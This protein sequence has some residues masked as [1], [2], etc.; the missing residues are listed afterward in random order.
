MTDRVDPRP[1]PLHNTSEPN[2]NRTDPRVES[3]VDPGHRGSDPNFENIIWRRTLGAGRL[4]KISVVRAS[5]I[6]RSERYEEQVAQRLFHS[7]HS[8]DLGT[9]VTTEHRSATF[10]LRNLGWSHCFR[11]TNDGAAGIWAHLLKPGLHK[12]NAE[13]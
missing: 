4:S 6:V 13:T 9:L 8:R 2:L 10:C 11:A 3:R 5:L 1:E 7:R 12:V